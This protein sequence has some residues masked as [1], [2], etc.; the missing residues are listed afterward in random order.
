MSQAAGATRWLQLLMGRKAIPQ[1]KEIETPLFKH[2]SYQT[3]ES[4]S[5][6]PVKEKEKKSFM[7]SY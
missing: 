5:P 1:C 3:A 7:F 4:Q 2:G 6:S